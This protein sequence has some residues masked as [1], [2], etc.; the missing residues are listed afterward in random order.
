[1]REA[2]NQADDGSN[3]I[4]IENAIFEMALQLEDPV[5]RSEFLARTFHEDPQ[6][7]TEMELLLGMTGNA[8][9]YFGEARMRTTEL[10]REVLDGFPESIFR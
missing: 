9:I 5:Q 3:P 4:A 8:S 2:I 7:R 10:A 1:M 6:G